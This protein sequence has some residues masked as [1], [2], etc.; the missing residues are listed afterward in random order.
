MNALDKFYAF[1]G[2][3]AKKIYKEKFHDP[4]QLIYLGDAVQIVYRSNKFHGGGDGKMAEYKHRFKKGVKL[5]MDE[6]C[7]IQLYVKG[8]QLK[9]TEAG[10][11]N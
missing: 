2:K 10:I 6:R 4:R 11:E 3:P 8:S 7:K 9:V 1:W 5:Y